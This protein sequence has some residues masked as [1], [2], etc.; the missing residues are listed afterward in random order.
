[1]GKRNINNTEWL[2]TYSDFITLLLTFFIV[3]YS[4]TDGISTSEMN[5]IISPFKGGEGVLDQTSVIPANDLVKRFKRAE[6]WE[7]FSDFIKEKGLSDQVGLELMPSGNRIILKE[8]LTFNSGDS[9]LL[10]GSKNVLKEITF[11]FD[12]SVGEIEVQGHTD[13]I[14][15][16]NARA[17]TNWNLGSERAISVLR[18][19]VENTNLPPELFKAATHAEFRPVAAND[20]D[21]GRKQNRRVEILIR[22]KDGKSRLFDPA[23]AA[24]NM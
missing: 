15:I 6:Q 13:N 24:K 19:L 8:S 2:V 7:R 17:K 10:S 9:E 3:M 12:D 4:A 14:P 16:R 23:E 5:A 22:Y 18:F 1:M 20:T 11:L 21:E